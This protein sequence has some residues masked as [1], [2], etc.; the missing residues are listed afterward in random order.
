VE[1]PERSAHKHDAQVI[2]EIEET[3][4]VDLGDGAAEEG[5]ADVVEE[6]YKSHAGRDD[7]Q[8]GDMVFEVMD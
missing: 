1:I 7:V 6:V 8:K 2:Q 3:K 5:V 4:V